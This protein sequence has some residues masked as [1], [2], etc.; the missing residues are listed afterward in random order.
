[1]A[2][3]DTFS[4]LEKGNGSKEDVGFFS[5]IADFGRGIIKGGVEDP[6]NGLIQISN[7]VFSAETPELQIVDKE[8][9]SRSVGGLLGNMTGKAVDFAILSM[10]NSYLPV[11]KSTTGAILRSGTIGGIYGGVLTPSDPNSESFFL[12]RAKNGAITFGTFAAMGAAGAKLDGFGLFNVAEGRSLLG[13]MAYG[14]LTGA[15]G[16]LANAELNAILNQGRI[17]PTVENLLVDTLSWS[18]FGAVSGGVNYGFNQY[19]AKHLHAETT[20]GQNGFKGTIDVQLDKLGKPVKVSQYLEG[21]EYGPYRW[22]SQL[23]T[24]GKWHDTGSGAYHTPDLTGIK[25]E[26]GG[27]I[28][29]RDHLYNHRYYKDGA[30]FDSDRSRAQALAEVYAKA[31]APTTSV[32]HNS[33]ESRAPKNVKLTKTGW[34]EHYPDK[35]GIYQVVRTDNNLGQRIYDAKGRITRAVP[36]WKVGNTVGDSHWRYNGSG[37]IQLSYGYDDAG[38]LSKISVKDLYARQTG[39]NKWELRQDNSAFKIEGKFEVL[40]PTTPNG[41]EQIS[42]TNKNGVRTQVAANDQAGLKTII[43]S[44][45]VLD[46]GAT[47]WNYVKVSNDGIPTLV[48]NKMSSV[49]VNGQKIANAAE[50]ALKPNDTV[51]ITMDVG[52]RYPIWKDF[53]F[54]WVKDAAQNNLGK[55]KVE[56]GKTFELITGYYD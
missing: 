31:G 25:I 42:F 55:Y 52:D 37:K 6:V 3:V 20:A 13:S 36:D 7:K 5:Q 1:M 51:K 29:T 44:N 34:V 56:A 33:Y 41:I 53:H 12:D 27:R 43:Q 46:P 49:T 32:Y 16:G 39:Q 22:D 10:A 9:A 54:Q 8:K 19:S 38:A 14:S 17:L 50:V 21:G 40:K 24:N 47:G 45:A 23:R 26:A 48:T 11:P 35:G 18:A 4:I 15:A 2:E 30:R 28:I